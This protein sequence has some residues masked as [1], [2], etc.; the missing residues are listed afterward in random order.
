MVFFPALVLLL[1]II[2]PHSSIALLKD[3]R[4]D[5]FLRRTPNTVWLSPGTN[6]P[7]GWVNFATLQDYVI[8]WMG[9][10]GNL[11]ARLCAQTYVKVSRLSDQLQI[12]LVGSHHKYY[13]TQYV[14]LQFV[15][16][17]VV[18]WEREEGWVARAFWSHILRIWRLLE[19]NTKKILLELKWRM[20]AKGLKYTHHP[21][22]FF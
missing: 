16:C 22:S 8:R 13:I 14:F 11:C 20:S 10:D 3:G 1:I 18:K 5:H 2:C 9:N 7:I 12:S 15:G 21:Y 19:T 4:R 17:R 6:R